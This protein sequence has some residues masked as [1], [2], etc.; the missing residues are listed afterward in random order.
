[1]DFEADALRAVRAADG[2]TNVDF[3]PPL[4]AAL[5]QVREEE[6]VSLAIGREELAL[7]RGAEAVVERRVKLP[8]RWVRSLREVPLV[9]ARGE[10]RA[11]LGRAAAV[12]L[13]RDLPRAAGKV[14][15]GLVA[16]ADGAR[17]TA[18]ETGAAVML[19]GAERLKC[20]AP[21]SV[22][23]DSLR[24]FAD[25]VTCASEWI[26]RFDTVSAPRV[27]VLFTNRAKTK[28]GVTELEVWK[29]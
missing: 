29:D 10:P 26:L 22:S 17:W 7:V 21:L 6:S 1:M 20:L 11:E 15:H 19:A 23:A 2:T 18:G 12:R 8:E 27:R 9:L 25:P 16:G 4:L 14:R 24:V 3:N 5:A 13:L 28:S